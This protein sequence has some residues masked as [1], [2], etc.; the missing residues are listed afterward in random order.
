MVDGCRGLSELIAALCVASGGGDPPPSLR[1]ADL[2]DRT[3]V[4]ATALASDGRYALVF[5]SLGAGGPMRLVAIDWGIRGAT[6]AEHELPAD[7][8]GHVTFDPASGSALFLRGAPPTSEVWLVEGGGESRRVLSPG[9]SSG[10]FDLFH[11]KDD[12]ALGGGR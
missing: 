3:Y 10:V 12:A 6:R 5:E 7:A 1:P 2:F 9:I 4:G 8:W 11:Q